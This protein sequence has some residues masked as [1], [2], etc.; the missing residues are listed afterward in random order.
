MK[1]KE[2]EFH[3][4]ESISIS[5]EIRFNNELSFGERFFLAEMKS[6]SKKNKGLEFNITYLSQCFQ[7]TRPTMMNWVTKMFNLG[8]MQVEFDYLNKNKKT[9]LKIK[10][11]K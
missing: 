5:K 10:K 3:P 11:I 6:L 2:R 1:K 4:E 8:L 7:V 9:I